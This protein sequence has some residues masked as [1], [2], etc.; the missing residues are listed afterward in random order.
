MDKILGNV[1]LIDLFECDY[2]SVNSTKTI[3]NALKKIV[4][5]S[6]LGLVKIINHE[7]EPQGV[8]SIAI[9]KE[10]HIA[11][12]SWPEYNFLSIDIFSCSKE[13]LN[14][15]KIINDAK[16]IF[17]ASRATYKIISRPVIE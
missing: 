14:L 17:K 9:I 3:V 16:R 11:I 6:N 4:E 5:E 1:Y 13:M 10:S 12:H 8:T 2:A 15:E 7:Y